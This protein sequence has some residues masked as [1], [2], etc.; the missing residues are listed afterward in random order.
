MEIFEC[1]PGNLP[2][3]ILEEDFFQPLIIGDTSEEIDLEFDFTKR[4]TTH[5]GWRKNKTWCGRHPR[6]WR[7][8]NDTERNQLNKWKNRPKRKK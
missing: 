6:Y 7:E 3:D 1:K 5:I 8:P 4:S 2:E